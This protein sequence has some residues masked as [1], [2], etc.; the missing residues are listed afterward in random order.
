MDIYKE[1]AL[2]YVQKHATESSTPE[3]LLAMFRDAQQKIANCDKE[4]KGKAFSFE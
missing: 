1:L 2:L 4:H 3:E